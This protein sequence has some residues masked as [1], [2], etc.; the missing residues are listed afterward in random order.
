MA[1]DN[2]GV[3]VEEIYQRGEFSCQIDGIAGGKHCV[4]RAAAGAQCLLHQVLA[5]V[6]AAF[7]LDGKDIADA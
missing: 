1:L 4:V 5:V 3:G 2:A 7:Y 6:E